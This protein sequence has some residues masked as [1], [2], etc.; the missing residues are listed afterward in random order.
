M[1]G[2]GNVSVVI[3]S[4]NQNEMIREAVDSVRRQTLRP[5]AIIV[6]DDGSTDQASVQVLDE[7]EQADDITVVRQGNAGPSAARNVGIR[8]ARTDCVTVLDGDDRLLPTFLETTVGLLDGDASVVAASGWLRTFGVL[9]AVVKPT[10]GTIA[11]FLSRNACPATFTFRRTVWEACGGYDESMRSGFEDWDF[12]LSLLTAAATAA[13]TTATGQEPRIAI[14]PRAIDRIP[15]R[16]GKSEHHQHDHASGNDALSHR[17]APCCIRRPSHGCAPGHRGHVDRPAQPVGAH[18]PRTPRV[19]G[20]PA[21][22]ARLH[23]LAHIR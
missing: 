20:E 3:T 2:M 18:G 14:A 9:D 6:V 17:Q 19:A 23:G 21:G 5:D 8:A 11:D 13:D 12:C 4:Y 22:F 7:L 1:V 10:G 15:H 16:A